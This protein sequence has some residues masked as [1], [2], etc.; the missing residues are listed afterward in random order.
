MPSSVTSDNVALEEWLRKWH[1]H[2][3]FADQQRSELAQMWQLARLLGKHAPLLRR[4]D[5][6]VR[7]LYVE[8]INLI[9][10]LFLLSEFLPEE[11]DMWKEVGLMD[12]SDCKSC[13]DG[14]CGCQR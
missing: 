9:R 11:H 1:R 7:S 5:T 13:Q 10:M 14:T 6:P 12:P 2:I 4:I 3:F 8:S